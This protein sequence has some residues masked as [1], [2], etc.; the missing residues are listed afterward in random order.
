[1]ESNYKN[2]LIIMKAYPFHKGH[3]S[4]INFG[5]KNCDILHIIIS[6]NKSQTI[7]GIDRYDAIQ[8]MYIDNK[9]VKASL[10]LHL[11]AQSQKAPS[12]LEIPVQT[13]ICNQPA[14]KYLM[15]L[16]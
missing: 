7:P 11:V 12:L 10:R 6:H 13:V 15:K 1:M 4:L 9:R 16:H 14:A 5:L 8:E 2:G 3:A